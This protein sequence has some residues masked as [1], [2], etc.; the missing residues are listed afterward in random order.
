MLDL[1]NREIA[2]AQKGRQARII[3]KMNSLEE[4]AIIEAL[5]RASQAGVRIDLIVRGFC[6]LRPGIKGVSENIHVRSIIGRFLEHSR[7]F[8]FHND[9]NYELF[10][11]SADW[12]ERNFF[13]RIETCFP[14]EDKRMKKKVLKEGLLNYLSDNTQS[15]ILQSDG[16]YRHNTPGN[17]KPRS[18]QQMLLEQYT[19]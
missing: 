1:I 10:C 13:R 18:A 16:T 7:I 2:F 15:W 5:Y 14:I 9:G 4:P 6:C 8:Y 19:D 12:M 17:S 11:A 3:A